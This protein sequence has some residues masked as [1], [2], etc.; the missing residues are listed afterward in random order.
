MFL[1]LIVGGLK[2]ETSHTDVFS[3]QGLA[4]TQTQEFW[5]ILFQVIAIQREKNMNYVSLSNLFLTEKNFS[6]GQALVRI[7]YLNIDT[8]V[9]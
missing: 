6:F 8:V 1:L 4:I 5:E 9:D 3:V 7:S 2:H